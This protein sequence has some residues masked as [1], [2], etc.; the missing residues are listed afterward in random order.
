MRFSQITA[1]VNAFF[2]MILKFHW[3]LCQFRNFV[4]K[5]ILPTVCKLHGYGH[6]WTWFLVCQCV[7]FCVEPRMNTEVQDRSS[8]WNFD[9]YLYWKNMIVL[10]RWHFYLLLSPDLHLNDFSLCGSF[11]SSRHSLVVL[12]RAAVSYLFNTG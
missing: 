9:K 5:G 11:S 10:M 4:F 8:N 1:H 7:Y 6:I 2:R 12:L 3:N